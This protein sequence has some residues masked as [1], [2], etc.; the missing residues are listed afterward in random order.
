MGR[1]NDLFSSEG[2]DDQ[3]EQRR[4]VQPQPAPSDAL[5]HDLHRMARSEQQLDSHSLEQVWQRL[6]AQGAPPVMREARQKPSEE[7]IIDLK[8]RK[9]MEKNDSS[10]GMNPLT[11]LAESKK[12]RS[13]LRIVS[14]SLIAAVAIITIVSFTVFSGVLLP[15]PQ[16]AGNST[17]T[18][19]GAQQQ[20]AISGAKLVC[21]IGVDGRAQPA[22]FKNSSVQVEWPV[23]GN[24]VAYDSKQSVIFSAKD[25]GGKKTLAHKNYQAAG[26]P[27]GK[28][29]ATASYE[30]YTL[31]IDDNNGNT[32]KSISFAQL[33]VHNLLSI[34]WSSDSTKLIFIADGASDASAI[35]SVDADGGN[36]KTLITVGDNQGVRGFLELSPGGKYAFM[37]DFDFTAKQKIYS[38]WDVSTGKKMS[39]LIPGMEILGLEFSP[40]SSL[41]A[42]GRYNQINIFSATNGKIVNT[43]D[44]KQAEKVAW[45]PDGKYLAVGNISISIYD[46]KA[47]QAV[48]TFGKVDDPAHQKVSSLAWSP[49][50]TGLVS[51]IDQPDDGKSLTP[52]NV[53]ALS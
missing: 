17:S 14:I 51:S 30:S 48:T 21:S 47:N 13:P 23:Q 18:I 39:D 2:I 22:A 25:C 20:K 35:K 1:D 10:W 27:D 38:I 31:D 34:V 32:I 40:D 6:Q 4:S 15:A 29:I 37:Y 9:T 53:W 28:K 44:Y 45:S 49:N 19:T 8:E 46:V 16:T 12:R 24:A 5:I 26:S 42:V 7:N 3:I 50:G 43:L 36:I 33:G 41:L 11:P 52:I